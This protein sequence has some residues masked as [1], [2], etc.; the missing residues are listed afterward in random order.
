MPVPAARSRAALED[1][2]IESLLLVTHEQMVD[3]ELEF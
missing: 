1:F 3:F 2:I